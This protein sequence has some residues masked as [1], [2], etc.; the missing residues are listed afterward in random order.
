MS[1]NELIILLIS[2][3]VSGIMNSIAGGG[4]FVAFPALVFLGY[5]PITANATSALA[6]WPGTL[7]SMIAY[8]KDLAAN[9]KKLPLYIFL[10]LIGGAIGALFLLNISNEN[11][12][13]IVPYLILTA[14][15]LFTIRTRFI[16]KIQQATPSPFAANSNFYN[17][18]MI[19]LLLAI[20]IYGGFFGAGMGI[21]LLALFSLMGMNNINQMNALRTYVGVCANSIAIIIFIISGIILWKQ[22]MIMALGS[23][24][25]GFFGAYYARRLPQIWVQ[26]FAIAIGWI[27]TLYFFYKY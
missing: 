15:L 20:A 7:A 11:F 23:A 17:L 5:S 12:S 22:A 24:T 25:G 18:I 2:G 10:S 9:S 16:N 6:L 21:L 1:F 3:F 26:R 8:K 4:S 19:L 27:L 13:Q 14:T